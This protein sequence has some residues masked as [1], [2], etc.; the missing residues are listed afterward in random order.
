MALK[1]MNPAQVNVLDPS[2]FPLAMAFEYLW[3][4]K[5]GTP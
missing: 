2:F 4:T 1:L 3:K 5:R